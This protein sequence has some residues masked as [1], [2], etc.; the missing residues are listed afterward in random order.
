MK[1][2]FFYK[3]TIKS[4]SIVFSL[5]AFEEYFDCKN[6][7]KLKQFDSI[8]IDLSPSLKSYN[9]NFETGFENVCFDFPI[10]EKYFHDA[11]SEILN[12]GYTEVISI[13]YFRLRLLAVKLMFKYSSLKDFNINSH[14]LLNRRKL[15]GFY[16]LA[17]AIVS[18]SK[19]GRWAL[20]D[21]IKIFIPKESISNYDGS[22]SA[23]R[24][25]ITSNEFEYSNLEESKKYTKCTKEISK[26]DYLRFRKMAMALVWPA[27]NLNNEITGKNLLPNNY[28]NVPAELLDLCYNIYLS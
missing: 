2:I 13:N 11:Y 19:D 24:F 10:K 20:I 16:D 21:Y 1:N 17:L 23:Y 9:F 15:I 4:A 22:Y 8:T 27:S 3:R 5:V 28:D 6:N 7:L 18:R 14:F 25:K 12:S 26:V